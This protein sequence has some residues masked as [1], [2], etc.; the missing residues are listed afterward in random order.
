MVE[1]GGTT[2]VLLHPEAGV[3]VKVVAGIVA[4]VFVFTWCVR[5]S[6]LSLSWRCASVR[7]NEGFVAQALLLIVLALLLTAFVP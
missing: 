7:A 4:G 3:P 6:L 1:V 2:D 5:F